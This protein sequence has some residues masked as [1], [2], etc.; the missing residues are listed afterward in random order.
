[1]VYP[2][3]T[4]EKRACRKLQ[5]GD[6]KMHRSWQL[7]FWRNVPQ[8]DFRTMIRPEADCLWEG[9]FSVVIK[10]QVVCIIRSEMAVILWRLRL[11]LQHLLDRAKVFIQPIENNSDRSTARRKNIVRCLQNHM[12]L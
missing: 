12:P 10:P 2:M 4:P 11:V 3:L 1:L 6:K 7:S 8:S 9:L 5:I